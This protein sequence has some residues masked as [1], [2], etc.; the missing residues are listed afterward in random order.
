M[1]K[2]IWQAGQ[3]FLHWVPNDLLD[4]FTINEQNIKNHFYP[5][6]ILDCPLIPFTAWNC[7]KSFG[8][9][10][11]GEQIRLESEVVLNAYL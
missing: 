9:G 11:S 3:L 1:E 10:T 6:T 2:L 7:P 4:V 5:L 8:I